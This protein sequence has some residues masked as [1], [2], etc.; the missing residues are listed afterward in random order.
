MPESP[1]TSEYKDVPIREL[2]NQAYENLRQENRELVDNYESKLS[3]DITVVIGSKV[4]TR[5]HMQDILQHKIKEVDDDVWKLKLGTTEVRVRDLIQSIPDAINLVDDYISSA[6]NTNPYTSIAWGG[7]SLLLPLLLNPSEQATSLAEGLE[8]ISSLIV[9]SRAWEDLYNRRYE[10]TIQ[11]RPTLP[12]RTA[13]KIALENLYRQILNFQTTSYCYYA[14]NTLTRLGQDMIKWNGW[15]DMLKEVKNKEIIFEKVREDCRDE[16]YDEESSA[17]KE[18]HHEAMC[19]WEKVGADIS[20]LRKAKERKMRNEFLQWLC[21]FD[22]SEIYNAA[23]GKH[24][25]GTGEWLLRDNKEFKT[26]ETSPSSLLWVY[27]KAGSGKTILSSSVVKRQR[28]R[29][30]ADPRSAFAY[31]FFSFSDQ[32]RQKVDVMLA[33]LIKQLYASRSDTQQLIKHLGKYK[34]RGERPDTGVFESA[35]IDASNMFSSVSIIIDALDEFPNL[36]GERRELLESLSRV[37][38]A[39]PQTH[40]MRIFCTSRPEPDI[41]ATINSILSPPLRTAI[42]LGDNSTSINSDIGLH[43]DSVFSSTSFIEWPKSLKDEAKARLLERADGMFQYVD[44]QF[45]ALRNLDTELSIRTALQQLPIGLDATYD[46][47]FQNLDQSHHAAIL[48]SLKW[49]AVS[50]QLLTVKELAEVFIA[51]VD[52]AVPIDEA[53]RLLKP[54]ICLKY[55]S[56]LVTTQSDHR[57]TLVRLA[58]FSVK[59]YLISDRITQGPAA[60]FSFTESAAHMEIALLCLPYHLH[61]SKWSGMI[62]KGLELQRYAAENWPLHLEMVPREKWPA[63]VVPLAI[64]AL[65]VRSQSLRILVQYIGIS[66]DSYLLHFTRKRPDM[67]Q[68]PHLYTARLGCVKLTEMLLYSSPELS[69]YWTWWDFDAGLREAAYGRSFKTV[70]FF[71]DRS[72]MVSTESD[73]SGSALLAAAFQG[74]TK[75]VNFLLM[76]CAY[77]DAGSNNLGN[78]LMAAAYMGHANIVGLLL[79]KGADVNT[80]HD[81]LGSVLRVAT[82]ENHFPVVQLLVERGANVELPRNKGGNVITFEMPRD[83]AIEIMKFLLKSGAGIDSQ[84]NTGETAL[85]KAAADSSY[86]SEQFRLLLD[87]GANVNAEGGEYG[88]PLQAACTNSRNK[89][90]V[91]LLLSKGADIKAQGGKYGNA[92]QAACYFHDY[93]EE[94]NGSIIELLLERGAE[95]N[96]LGGKFGTA[97]QAACRVQHNILNLVKRRNNRDLVEWLLEN[98]ANAN[99]QGGKYG[100]ALQAACSRGSLDIAQLLIN[101]GADVHALG[102]KFGNALQA[103]AIAPFYDRGKRGQ[104]CGLVRLLLDKGVNINEQGGRYGAALQAACLGDDALRVRLLLDHGA[105]VN[106]EGGEYGT[107]LQAACVANTDKKTLRSDIVGILIE[108]GANVNL[109]G[110]KFGN[111]WHAAASFPWRDDNGVLRLLLDNGVDI[112][113]MQGPEHYTALHAAVQFDYHYH[114]YIKR[115][116]ERLRLLL[117]YGA[118]VNIQAGMYGSPLQWACANENYYSYDGAMVKLP[119]VELLLNSCPDIDINESGGLLGP[120]LQAAAYSGQARSVKLLLNKGAHVNTRGGKYGS[121]LNAAVFRGFWDIVKI[122]IDN[123]A[124]S[125]RQQFPGADEEW[126]AQIQEEDGEEAV[127][128]YRV[129]WQNQPLNEDIQGVVDIV[130]DKD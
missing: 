16:A 63:K 13:Y 10:S 78:A 72:T 44:C 88:Y 116:I 123:G 54:E 48:R 23:H 92:L 128:R 8:Y 83:S 79:N 71:L 124:Q 34:E 94:L 100:N 19:R 43:I 49:L 3:G 130:D 17:A 106:A 113:D 18:R 35:L 95:I 15:D 42:D 62:V 39:M 24:Q 73:K 26:W 89:S 102:G 74:D 46:R 99:V 129:F 56:S 87:M 45:E 112:N 55:L 70:Q 2:W 60:G 12:S 98:G 33:S 86:G 41:R 118:D 52:C 59:E 38:T 97:L 57:G 77:G 21:A 29:H 14:S 50:N 101:R 37:I 121:A 28:E 104:R 25:T 93:S 65:A 81:E 90:K 109:Q 120:A 47:L 76:K 111:A 115:S 61:R 1:P 7:V 53:E 4:L 91:E 66:H 107:A 36:D 31:F 82:A 80:E 117:E 125:D 110:G 11:P 108:H 64:R 105:Q 103:A 122:L 127:A 20:E 58:H 84:S 67:N 9:R 68:W 75:I 119:M 126:L 85:H 30:E 51:R 69:K 40:N 96:A 6:V 114:Y 5:D 22:P 32:E 27:G